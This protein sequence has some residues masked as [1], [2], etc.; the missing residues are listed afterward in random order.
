[1]LVHDLREDVPGRVSWDHH[2]YTRNPWCG[3]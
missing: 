3:G 2:A 1:L